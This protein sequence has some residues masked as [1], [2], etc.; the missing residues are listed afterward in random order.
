MPADVVESLIFKL[1]HYPKTGAKAISD[2]VNVFRSP[3]Q[4]L[5]RMRVDENLNRVRLS[6]HSRLQTAQ[7]RVRECAD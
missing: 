1:R 6:L 3:R 5:P 4:T 2:A 7:T